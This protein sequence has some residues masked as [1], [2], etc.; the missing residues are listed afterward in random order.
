LGW[1]GLTNDAAAG[2]SISLAQGSLFGSGQVLA[3]Q[4]VN[5]LA[6]CDSSGNVTYSGLNDS[7][8][9]FGQQQFAVGATGNSGPLQTLIQWPSGL[10]LVQA[11]N[12]ISENA[13]SQHYTLTQLLTNNPLITAPA[14]ENVATYGSL[15]L[16][17]LM[18]AAIIHA[19]RA[20]GITN[21][22]FFVPQIGSYDTH[23]G[24]ITQQNNM[25]ADLD[26]GLSA[27]QQFLVCAGLFNNVTTFTCSEFGRSFAANN[28]GGT[29]HAWGN[30][31]LIMGGGVLGG[32]IFGE[33]PDLTIGGSNDAFAPL[34][35]CSGDNP[36]RMPPPNGVLLPTTSIAQYG[37]TLAQWYGVN[38]A[39]FPNIFP[40]LGAQKL[41]PMFP[42]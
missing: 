8:L 27:F 10:S 38:P 23:G 11:A 1:G 42:S 15:A 18:V 37:A 3:E 12:S 19:S 6:S 26:T 36:A 40:Y 16:S 28:N 34:T 13:L 24:Q 30:H 41:L 7:P 39:S 35:G 17:L 32:Q 25:L 22:I 31:H 33:F 4:V 29:D 2:Q 21:Q 14:F 5:P 9:I 20:A